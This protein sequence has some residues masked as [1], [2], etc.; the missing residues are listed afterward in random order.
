MLMAAAR[1]LADLAREDVVDEVVRAYGNEKFTFGTEYLL[2]KPV[3]PRIFVRESS[4]VAAQAV[5]D[6]VARLP[7]EPAAYEE[8]LAI[9]LGAGQEMMRRLIL[10][11]RQRPL[12][13]VFPEG[14]NETILRACGILCDEG[15]ADPILLGA[16]DEVRRTIDQLGLELSGVQIVDPA[17]DP[18]AEIY[19]EEY[20]VMRQR[21]GVT[22]ATAAKRIRQA[23]FFG[24]MMLHCGDAD[25]MIGGEDAHYAES[26]RTLIETIGT[27][28]AVRRISGHY[29]VV[30]P[31]AVYF[32]AD[33]TVNIDPDAEDLAETALQAARL[34]R[35]IGVE[36]RVAMLSFANFGSVDHPFTT[37]VR[38]ATEIVKQKKPDLIIDGEMQLTPAVDG[39]IRRKYFP[40][41]DLRDDAN[42]LIFPDLQSGLLALDLLQAMSEAVVVGPVLMGGR[43]PA[44]LLQ[45]GSSVEQVVNLTTI[46]AVQ[47]AAQSQGGR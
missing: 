37:K 36:P 38:Q 23:K 47:A 46:G 3:D 10:K 35:S 25:M 14:T 42:V 32:L 8:S 13:V 12:R 15:I 27:A 45:Y 29:M 1:A 44:H 26:L 21:R 18:R 2:P 11:A 7:V 33:C 24:A 17:R 4:A 41:S 22:R 5:E 31:K 6:G 28:P 16:E 40:F 19:L 39:A 34:V 9:R 20:Y 43:L 30:L